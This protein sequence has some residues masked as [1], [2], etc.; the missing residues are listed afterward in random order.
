MRRASLRLAIALLWGGLLPAAAALATDGNLATGTIFRDCPDCPEMVVLPAGSFVMGSPPQQKGRSDDEGPQRRVTIPNPVAVGRFEVTRGQF[1]RFVAATGHAMDDRC[2]THENGVSRIRAGRGW[3]HPGFPQDDRHPATC[4]RWDDA[5]AYARWLSQHTGRRYRL[6]SEAEWE[7]G[8]RGGTTRSRHWGN[9]ASEQ[10]IHANGAD[11]AFA[12][13]VK[14]WR[15]SVAP[16]RDGWAFT[17]PVGSLAANGY[18]LHDMSG[19]VAEWVADCWHDGYRGA[20]SDGGAWTADGNC[21]ERVLRGGA[22]Y[23]GPRFLSSA[24]RDAGERFPVVR[25]RSGTVREPPANGH[26]FRIARA[27]GR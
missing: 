25:G 19:N 14:E 15:W 3:R 11:A 9:S 24:S 6:L 26:G 12:A 13:R 10:C 20:P 8:A 17:A 5:V 7:Y 1:A 27:L 16:C 23:S 18:R 22:W 2:W 4:V 21:N